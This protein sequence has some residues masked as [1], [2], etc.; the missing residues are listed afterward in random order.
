MSWQINCFH[1][2]ETGKKDPALFIP[3]LTNK[4]GSQLKSHLADILPPAVSSQEQNDDYMHLGET[5]KRNALSKLG[6]VWK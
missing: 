4:E 6:M 1:W 5:L 2:Q 3:S